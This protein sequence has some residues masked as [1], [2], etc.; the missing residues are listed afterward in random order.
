MYAK[1]NA[2]VKVNGDTET[3]SVERHAEMYYLY[4]I[5][6]RT[7]DYTSLVESS[8]NKTN[9]SLLSDSRQNR[10]GKNIN[11]KPLSS[12]PSTKNILNFR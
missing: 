5:V 7:H 11:L 1:E 2:M 3:L 8:L 9:C 12:Q 10:R 4:D 6:V